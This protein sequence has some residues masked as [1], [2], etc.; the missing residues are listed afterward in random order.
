MFNNLMTGTNRVLGI[1]PFMGNYKGVTPNDDVG[2]LHNLYECS[3]TVKGIKKVVIP[4]M[5][6]TFTS[7]WFTSRLSQLSTKY[8]SYIEVYVQDTE[9]T[10]KVS[11]IISTASDIHISGDGIIDYSISSNGKEGAIT[12]YLDSLPNF[13]YSHQ[14]QIG[15]GFAIP[16]EF[17]NNNLTEVSESTK[18][19]QVIHDYYYLNYLKE[20]GG[21]DLDLVFSLS[22]ITG[23][24]IFNKAYTLSILYNCYFHDAVRRVVVD[25]ITWRRTHFQ[26]EAQSFRMEDMV[27]NGEELPLASFGYN[28][29]RNIIMNTIASEAKDNADE[30]IEGDFTSLQASTLVRVSIPASYPYVFNFPST[31]VNIR[32][33]NLG[34]EIT[35]RKDN[36]YYD[37]P[38]ETLP[39][40]VF[41]YDHDPETTS[42]P[43]KIPTFNRGTARIILSLSVPP[44]SNQVYLNAFIGLIN[45]ETVQ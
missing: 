2:L 44:V 6:N 27:Y 38:T 21:S 41:G 11:L 35:L 40:I 34:T 28:S 42:Y 31:P 39:M 24:D 26:V 29:F 25:T 36:Y 12:I 19:M 9:G 32:V 5:W 22:S 18:F 16:C 30:I 14:Y 13:K 8:Y 4:I 45:Q 1:K 7:D 37:F 17:Y 20:G 33:P 43:T 10:D 3:F 15:L 23:Y